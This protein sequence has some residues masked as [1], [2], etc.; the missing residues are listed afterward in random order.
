VSKLKLGP[1]PKTE[2]TKLTITLSVVLKADLD[3]YAALHSQQHGEAV[4][5]ATI[6]PHIVSTFIGR[7]RE[8]QRERKKK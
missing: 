5:A 1:L 7:D 8:F 4:D 2:V 6:I 3:H